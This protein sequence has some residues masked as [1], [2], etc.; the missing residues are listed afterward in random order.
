MDCKGW[1]ARD[2]KPKSPTRGQEDKAS[3]HW[4][5]PGERSG[6]GHISSSKNTYEERKITRP[7]STIATRISLRV[8]PKG[9]E[10]VS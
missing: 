8:P 7:P 6:H 1:N 9:P 10:Q 3:V 2:G 5:R 4:Q